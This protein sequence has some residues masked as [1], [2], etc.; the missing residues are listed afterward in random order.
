[1]RK[2]I[3]PVG[4]QL[5][6]DSR[7]PVLT[8]L[9][10]DRQRVKKA[11][12]EFDVPLRVFVYAMKAEKATFLSTITV[13]QILNLKPALRIY[14]GKET[15]IEVR[16][17]VNANIGYMRFKKELSLDFKSK[18]FGVVRNLF[19]ESGLYEKHIEELTKLQK[20]TV[21]KILFYQEHHVDFSLLSMLEILSAV[22][23][24]VCVVY[25]DTDVTTLDLPD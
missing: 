18:L 13:A 6:L 11:L 1:M 20:N 15:Y 19:V 7:E 17:D 5:C 22:S 21:A 4:Q 9:K 16:S 8:V 12:R 24:H 23:K 10:E 3:N 14:T 25:N 2:Q